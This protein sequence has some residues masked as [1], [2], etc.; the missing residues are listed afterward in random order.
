MR[1]S[2]WIIIIFVVAAFAVGAWAY[3][4]LPAMVPAHW[5]MSGVPSGSISSVWAAFAFPALIAIL[6]LLFFFIPRI[7]PKRE[8][9]QKFRKYYD[10]FVVS[11]LILFFWIFSLLL[12]R[13][14]GYQ[15]DFAIA[16]IPAIAALF[17]I[18]GML[19]PHTEPNWT[20]GIR[21]PWTISSDSVWKKTHRC[22]GRLFK[23]SAVI[24]LVGILFPKY[25]AWFIAGPC[26]LSG[27]GLV[28][29]SYVR[30]EWERN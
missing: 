10:Y 13:Y 29:Y 19:L 5:N 30:Y 23:G 27:L 18:S 28:I 9:I 15:F 16:L 24:A 3:P 14:L 12:S 11:L 1:I 22:G 20:I 7:D 8:N 4:Q 6:G 26:V 17:W 21:T 25:A 2:E